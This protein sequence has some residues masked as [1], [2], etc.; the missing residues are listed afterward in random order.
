[1]KL[2]RAVWRAPVELSAY[3]ALFA[4]L[5]WPWLREAGHALPGGYEASTPG[6]A[7]LIVWVLAWVTRA[8]TTDPARLFHAP[9][10]YPSPNQLTG[11]ESFFSAQAV[12][13]PLFLAT[14]NATLATTLTVFLTYPL[15]ALAM[16]RLLLALG[17]GAGAA[18]VGGGVARARTLARSGEYTALATY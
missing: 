1:M 12:F 8:L 14:D 6:D 4:T 16:S 13:A 2:S 18:F 7:R 3:V 15:A 9:I 5:A 11:S 10:F 17:C